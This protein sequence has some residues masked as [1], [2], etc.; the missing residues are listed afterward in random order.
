MHRET[1]RLILILA[2]TTLLAPGAA[3]AAPP[4]V[5]GGWFRALPSAVPSGGYF[6]LRNDSDKTITLI[7]A[8]SPACGALALHRSM[9]HGGMAMM[10]HVESV[11]VAPGNE[12]KFA[13]GGYHL[14]CMHSTPQMKAGA[15]VPVTLSFAD[16][17]SVTASFAVRNAA[18]K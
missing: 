12:V 10:E 4:V 11:D 5:T 13:P 16:G 7:G 9:D 6:T 14:M 3:Q 18:G 8:K 2:V 1:F 17:R 15:S